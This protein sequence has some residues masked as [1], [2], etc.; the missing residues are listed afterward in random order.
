M[1]LHNLQIFYTHSQ[2]LVVKY[3]SF[4]LSPSPPLVALS[5]ATSLVIGSLEG[6][7]PIRR[8]AMTFSWRLSSEDFGLA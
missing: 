2:D 1:K 6:R 5:V 8:I 4:E 3:V 7:T